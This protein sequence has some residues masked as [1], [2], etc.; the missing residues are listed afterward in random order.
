[1]KSAQDIANFFLSHSYG[2]EMDDLTNLKLQKLLY[3]TQGY[4]L[5][6]LDRPI[7]DD[8]IL[9]WRHGPVVETVWRNYNQY[10]RTPLPALQNYSLSNFEQDEIIVL[11]KVAS[12]YGHFPPWQ[13]RD[14]THEEEPWLSTPR[15]LY[16]DRSLIK[17]YFMKKL[18]RPRV[19]TKP[20]FDINVEAIQ[21]S[22]DSGR[23][24]VP[25]LNNPKDFVKWL[26]R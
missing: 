21:S 11:N 16:I 1:M 3:Y 17:N 15:D 22:I 18:R 24:D 12:D 19:N 2:G 8:L 10:G 23:V 20:T 9:A 4:S 14:M 13:L 6:L 7:F 5:A 26:K 25:K